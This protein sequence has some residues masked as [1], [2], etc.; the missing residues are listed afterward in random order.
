MTQAIVNKAPA[1]KFKIKL[2]YWPP[3]VTAAN[4]IVSA[5]ATVSP[6]GLTLLGAVE[7][8]GNDVLQM[9]EGGA[10]GVDY[11]VQFAI[12][13]TDTSHYANPDYDAILVRVR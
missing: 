6:L 9:I 3:D 13:T 7:I 1:E 8:D 10:A 4:Q 5:T 11:L 12:T 2:T